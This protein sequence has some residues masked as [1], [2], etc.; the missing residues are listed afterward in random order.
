MLRRKYRYT[1]VN[2]CNFG[3]GN[4]V[5]DMTSKAQ[6][7]KEKIQKLDFIKMKNFS[8]SKDMTEHMER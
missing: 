5:L 1:G 7:P 2:L 6:A 4:G 8:A 3:L